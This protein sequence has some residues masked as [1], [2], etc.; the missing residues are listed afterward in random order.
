MP[1]TPTTPVLPTQAA[2]VLVTKVQPPFDQPARL[3]LNPPLV[4][5]FVAEHARQHVETSHVTPGTHARVKCNRWFGRGHVTFW[6]PQVAGVPA[7]TPPKHWSLKVDASKS[8][9]A[10]PL[11]VSE[12]C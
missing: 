5:R 1:G 10:V 7:Q 2:F 3:P 11:A 8:V 12:L 6:L 4:I 9:H